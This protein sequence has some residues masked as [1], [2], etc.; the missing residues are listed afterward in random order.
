MDFGGQKAEKEGYS[1]TLKKP[2]FK[3][4]NA[5]FAAKKASFKKTVGE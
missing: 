1:S 5:D 4:K 2:L 3:A